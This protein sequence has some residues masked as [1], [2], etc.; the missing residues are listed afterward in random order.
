MT[1]SPK[2][3]LSVI[4]TYWNEMPVPVDTIAWHLGLGPTAMPLA[5]KVSGAIRRRPNG[6]YEI[7]VNSTHAES[8]K[9]FTVAHEIGHYVYHRDRLGLGTG[10]TLAFRTDGSD[11]PN[12]H[13]G[14][15]EEREAN[16]FAAN[17]LMPKHLLDR[18]RAE[19][20]TDHGAMARRLGVSTAALRI[21]LGL[22]PTPT[23]FG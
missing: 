4:K 11:Y 2:D 14:P 20:I 16:T 8:R 17:L 10:D 21:K 12:P 5:D 3:A 19:G 1:Q 18:L 7:L 13:I 22:P 9:R 23:L 15:R 6:G